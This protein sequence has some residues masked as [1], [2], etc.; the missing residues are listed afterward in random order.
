MRKSSIEARRALL[1]WI[2]VGTEGTMQTSDEN[3]DRRPE[4]FK[5]VDQ[6]GLETLQGLSMYVR[7]LPHLAG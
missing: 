5:L 7:C 6:M 1:C 4:F 3:N 2:M